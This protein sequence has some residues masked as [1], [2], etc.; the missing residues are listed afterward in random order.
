MKAA[1]IH[2]R[3]G[4]YIHFIICKH[5]LLLPQE[6]LVSIPWENVQAKEA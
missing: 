2:M 1:Y 4:T 3:S 5:V 6:D